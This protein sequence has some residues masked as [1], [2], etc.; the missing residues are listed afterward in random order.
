[1]TVLFVVFIRRFITKLLFHQ[2]ESIFRYAFIFLCMKICMFLSIRNL[3]LGE[4]RTMFLKTLE[5]CV[6]NCIWNL[7]IGSFLF[8][9]AL[10]LRTPSSFSKPYFLFT[11]VVVIKEQSP[12]IQVHIENHSNRVPEEEEEEEQ[13]SIAEQDKPGIG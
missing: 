8:D 9:G 5:V 10:F 2:S 12:G 6:F 7:M 13:V 3:R 4:K 1:M 11:L